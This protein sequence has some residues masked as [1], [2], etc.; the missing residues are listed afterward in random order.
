MFN[1]ATGKF[2]VALKNDSFSFYPI[3]YSNDSIL[4]TAS[5][6]WSTGT[7]VGLENIG[8]TCYLNSLLQI[9]FSIPQFVQILMQTS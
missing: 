3:S 9:Y 2:R 4:D 8:Q 6:V 5:I 7:P 1:P